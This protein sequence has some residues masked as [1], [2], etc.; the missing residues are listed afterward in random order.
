MTRI[1]VLNTRGEKSGSINLPDEIFKVKINRLLMVQ[2]VRVYL[3]NQRQS[4]AKAKTRGEVDASGRKIYRQ[5]GTGRAR[6]GDIK[7]P[8]F[9]KGGKAHGPSGKQNYKL[10]ISKIMKKKALFSALSSKLKSKQILVVDGL[11]KV[12][13]KTKEMVKIISN[14]N[15]PGGGLISNKKMKITIILPRVLDNVM[16]A[17]R[18]IKGVN[19]KQANLLTT[20]EVVNGGDIILMKESIEVLKETFLGKKKE[21]K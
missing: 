9:V 10:K 8:I 19:L 17:A 3:S 13:P 15:P 5:K 20:Y 1:D 4:P 12:A 16:R 18:N 11:A 2:A 6:H 21:I 14:F 7:A